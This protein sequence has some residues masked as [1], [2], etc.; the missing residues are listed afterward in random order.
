MVTWA[1]TRIL[2]LNRLSKQT[3]CLFAELQSQNF[4]LLATED[5]VT[6]FQ[7]SVAKR[8]VYL[9]TEFDAQ[10]NQVDEY[11]VVPLQSA[12]LKY[13]RHC[14][15]FFLLLPHMLCN[16]YYPLQWDNLMI[17]Q[18]L[19]NMWLRSVLFYTISLWATKWSSKIP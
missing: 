15:I 6:Y 17:F 9:V 16:L 10:C 7:N 14:H 13:K 18:V 8:Y 2:C 3:I 11:S 12:Y 19:F 5:L 1:Y 4:F